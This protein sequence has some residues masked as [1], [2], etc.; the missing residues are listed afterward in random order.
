MAELA[1][2]QR[3][4]VAEFL[5]WDGEPDRRYE[6]LDGQPT[7]MAP[8]KSFHGTISVN[9]AVAIDRHLEARPPCR[10]QGEAGVWVSDE[11]FLVADLAVTCSPAE[12]T[13][14]VID[15]L[16]IVEVLSPGTRAHDKGRKL[17]DYKALASVR[18]IWLVESEKRW[19]EVWERRG[20]DWAGRDHVGRAAFASLTL[21][22]EVT[23][24]QLYRNTGL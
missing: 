12:N 10:V 17:D 14:G 22:A 8:A 16:L 24:D 19:V 6:L 21:E 11:T 18:E 3:M 7:M 20:E 4:T 15:P 23:L 9:A 1:E 13:S 2:K 5:A